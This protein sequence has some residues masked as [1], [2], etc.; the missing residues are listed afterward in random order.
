MEL[1]IILLHEISEDENWMILLTCR[2]YK[3]DHTKFLNTMMVTSN[4]RRRGKE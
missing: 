3:F 4:Y 1:E 2:L